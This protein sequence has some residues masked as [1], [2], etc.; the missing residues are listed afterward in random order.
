MQSVCVAREPAEIKSPQQ[1]FSGLLP[2]W[3]PAGIIS[4]DV[5]R[6]LQ[7]RY[8]RLQ[9]GHVGTL[10]PMAEGVLA[11]LLGTATRL[12]D[13]LL[14]APK[15]Y[16]FEMIF[17]SETDTLDATGQVIKDGMRQDITAEEL[18]A[19]L[20]RFRGWID[21]VPPLFSA[22]RYQG[23]R[24][25]ELARAGKGD[26]VP[27]ADLTRRVFVDDLRCLSV[28]AGRAYL[29][30]TC[31]K[32]LYVRS[33]GRDIAYALG[34]CATVTR[35]IRT[36]ASM[37]TRAEAVSLEMID[38]PG[39]ELVD[40][41]IPAARIRLPIPTL[42]VSSDEVCRRLEHG[43]SVLLNKA[44]FKL[45]NECFDLDRKQELAGDSV[46]ILR[47]DNS[48]LGLGVCEALA[49]DRLRIKIK[50]RV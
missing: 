9:I 7:K 12:Q 16:E 32:G 3:K 26:E 49:D 29:V 48:V 30:V 37:L 47:A 41:L 11:L 2:I 20:P 27:I 40:L 33:L 14:D 34:S 23:Q 42:L 46:R 13:C 5:S 21:Q 4:K 15:T 24:L 31:S 45:Q 18:A 44:D 1:K 22:V 38:A 8:G 17:G 19:V 50:R 10:D 43:Q 36:A 35:I 6:R 25:H 39:V 28:D